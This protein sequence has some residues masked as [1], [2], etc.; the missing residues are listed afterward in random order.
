MTRPI[1]RSA[2]IDDGR[3][4]P[5]R[6]T[7]AEHDAAKRLGLSDREHR[8]AIW[9]ATGPYW[10]NRLALV[11]DRARQTIADCELLLVAMEREWDAFDREE[12]QR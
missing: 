3:V 11:A 7:A 10:R 6:Y 2:P 5:R 9:W 8:G 1:L 12:A 4:S